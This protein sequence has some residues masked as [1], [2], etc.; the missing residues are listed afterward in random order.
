MHPIERLRWIARARDEAPTTLAVEAAWTIS[1]LAL[2]EP[3]AVV[4]AC[5]RLLESHLTVGPIWWVA[6]TVLV[7]PDPDQAARRAV[8]ELFSDPTAK[9]LAGELS[10]RLASD[11][12]IVVACPADTV[13]EALGHL[14]S[15]VVRVVG[16]SPALRGEVR[17]FAALVHEA[18]GWEFEDARDAV[19]GA[20]VV[21][22]EALAAGPLGLLVTAEAALVARAARDAS[23]P[24]WGIA[25]VGRVL[26]Q[27]LLGEMLRR[28][29]DD[30]ELIEPGGLDAVIGPSGLEEPGEALARAGCPSAPELLVRAG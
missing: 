1:E 15:A 26:H 2:Y 28:A 9:L 23:V 16:S 19:N 24:L 30:V 21:L 10:Q 29:S 4:T 18:S 13:R 22:V 7:A 6:A 8:G 3:P 20:T 14:P 5:R 25:G 12:A 11:A 17:G 27:Q